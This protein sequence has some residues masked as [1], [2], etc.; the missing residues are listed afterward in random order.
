MSAVTLAHDTSAALSCAYWDRD[1]TATS[2]HAICAPCELAQ[3]ASQKRQG[4][5]EDIG[6][7]LKFWGIALAAILF[8]TWLAIW[9]TAGEPWPF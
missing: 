7:A 4:R 3:R 6:L 5:R 9:I 2:Y 1:M 8:V